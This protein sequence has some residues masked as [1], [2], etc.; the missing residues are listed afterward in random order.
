M[1]VASK[2]L[3]RWTAA[4]LV[5]LTPEGTEQAT[6]TR[7][8]ANSPHT[9]KELPYT[10]KEFTAYRKITELCDSRMSES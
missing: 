9:E 3:K 6:K 7:I 10:E 4:L 2:K 5:A 1:F 8:C